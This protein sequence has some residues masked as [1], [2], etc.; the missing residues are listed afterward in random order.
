MIFHETTLKDAW[1]IELE[2]R[3]D[4]RG[5]FARTMCKEEFAQHGLLNDFVQQ[6]TSFSAQKGTLRGL[7][8]QMQPHGEA[9]L[10]RCL[11]GAIVDIIVDVRADSPT[12]LQHQQFELTDS[13]RSQLYV[14]PGYAH[15]FQTLSNDVEVSYLVSAAYCP[16]AERG[17][18]Y[19]DERL[20]IDWP[21]PVTVLSEK[22]AHWPLIDEATKPLY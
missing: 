9:K 10:V 18:R 5:F 2:P 4:Q 3:G 6:N 16:Q 13:N 14:P 12:F 20:Q 1:L 22:D 15:G 21:V 8:Y 17:L 11:R 7:H 19:D